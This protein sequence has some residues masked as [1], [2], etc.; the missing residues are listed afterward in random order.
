ML[1]RYST[2]QNLV[3]RLTENAAFRTF[4]TLWLTAENEAVRQS[5][6]AAL[7]GEFDALNAVEQLEVKAE[8]TR[9]FRKLPELAEQLLQKTVLAQAA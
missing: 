8:F 6:N 7:W 1:Q 3:S 4:F 9:C 5:L 2:I